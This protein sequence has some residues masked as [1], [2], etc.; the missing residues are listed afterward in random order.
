MFN[1]FSKTRKYDCP[2]GRPAI[3]YKHLNDAI[4]LE[5]RNN[6]SKSNAQGNVVGAGDGQISIENRSTISHIL[7]AIDARNSSQVLDFRNAYLAYMSDPCGSRD[8]LARTTQRIMDDRA[9][10]HRLQIQADTLIKLMETTPNNSQDIIDLSK[11]MMSALNL[12][13]PDVAAQ[14]I[15]DARKDAKSMVGEGGND[16]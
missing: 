2:D 3:V 11:I 10:L 13:P 8:L 5:L 1:I 15:S 9:F 6:E 7:V 12:T 4:P 14:A 16:E